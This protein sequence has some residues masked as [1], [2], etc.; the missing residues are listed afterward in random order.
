MNQILRT[1]QN[2]F[3]QILLTI[4]ILFGSLSVFSQYNVTSPLTCMPS[5]AGASTDHIFNSVTPPAA[6]GT[7]TLYYRGDID[8]ASEIISLFDENGVLIGQTIPSGDFADQC[9]A[10][11][12]SIT[13]PV[14]VAQLAAWT[15]DGIVTFTS[16]PDNSVN[17]TL[18]TP[19][20]ATYVNLS[21]QDVTGPDNIGIASIDGPA[22]FCAGNEDV[23]VTVT[24]A[25]TNPVDTFTVSWTVDNGPV[26]SV[27]YDSISL[28]TFN[29]V[30]PNSVQLTLVNLNITAATD[31]KVWTS[32]P[33][34]NPDT[35]N[36]NDTA[37]T[38]FT[39]A[40][41]GTFTIDPAGSGASN[42]VDFASAI[43]SVRTAGLCGPV[44]FNIAAGT[45][46]ENVY[47]DQ[48]TGSSPVNSI[49]FDGGSAATTTITYANSLD[50][51]TVFLDG[52]DFVTFT[53]LT[54]ENT[55]QDGTATDAFGIYLTNQADFNTISNCTFNIL[56]TT[57]FDA[58]AIMA[59]ASR[60]AASAGNNANNLTIFDVNIP[61]SGRGIVLYGGSTPPTHNLT[62]SII[63]CS[64]TD[65][66]STG[67][68][69]YVDGQT[70]LTIAGNTIRTAA[71]VNADGIYCLQIDQYFI[72]ENDVRV[73]DWGLYILDGNDGSNPGFQ[74]LV[75]NN[76]F[77]SDA[78]YGMYLNDFEYTDIFHNSSSGNPAI[79]INDQ[80]NTINFVNN[81]FYSTSD[82]AFESDDA[83]TPT[84][85]IDFNIYF[86][87]GA[88]PFDI[89]PSVF[90]DLASWQISDP[91][92]NASSIEGDPV[93]V[94]PLSDLH[95]NGILPNDVGNNAAGVSIDIDGDP[96]PFAGATT[97]DIGADEF[98]PPSCP[99]PSALAVVAAFD[100]SALVG[101][102]EQGTATNWEVEYGPTGFAQG[103]GT[104]AS[105][106][107]N[108]YNITGLMPQTSYDFYVRS[109]CGAGDTSGWSGPSSFTTTCAVASAPFFDNLDG[110]G[111][112]ADNGGS[113]INS[114]IDQCWTRIPDVT[115]TYSWRVRT[116]STGSGSGSTGPISDKSGS[117]NYI[118]TEASSGT[119]GSVAE[120]YTPF[121]DVTGI[122]NPQVDYW[123]HFYGTQINIMYVDYFDGTSWS[124]VDSIAG[125]QQ[126]AGTDP[127]LNKVI[128]L[129]PGTVIQIRFRAISDGC[130]AGDL[131]IDE[132]F[133]G[134]PPT[135][136]APQSV[137]AVVVGVDSAI[138]TLSDSVNTTWEVEYGIAGFIPGTGTSFVTTDTTDTI[139][140]LL[141]NTT[142]EVFV[143]AICGPGDTS[144]P[145]GP[146]SFTTPCSVFSAPWADNL[147]G[148]TWVSDNSSSSINSQIDQCWERNPNNTT[149]YSWRVRTT[150]TGSG[151][152]STGPAADKS[153]TGNYAYTEASSGASGNVAILETPLVDISSLAIPQLKFWYHF[154]G[155]TINRMYIEVSDGSGWITLD[156][157]VGQQQ[158]SGTA[159]WLEDSVIIPVTGIVQARF[160]AI[161][162]G[163]CAG[164]L[165]IDEVSISDGPSCVP[166]VAISD[167]V[168]TGDSVNIHFTD[169]SGATGWVYEYG[170]TGFT[171][172]TG[173][174]DTAF[175]NPFGIGGLVTNA[176]YDIY[177]RSICGA[178]TSS[179]SGVY[180]FDV[181]T[182]KRPT[183]LSALPLTAN[184]VEFS[185]M[186]NSGA[187]QWEIEY[188]SAGFIPGTGTV[189]VTSNNPDTI[190]GL[191]SG[192]SY[193]FFV[194]ST[195]G[196]SD[197]SLW[198]GPAT[199][200]L[201]Y[202]SGGPSSTADSE[203]TNVLLNGSFGSIS[204]LQ[205]CPAAAG[206][207]DFTAQ[208]A[209]LVTGLTYTL[210]VTFGTCGGTFPGAGEAWID[211]NQ[212]LTFEPG[213]SLGTWSGTGEPQGSTVFNGQFTFTVPSGT[214][215]G[216]TRM[217]VMQW[218]GGTNPLD[219]C[220]TFT[221]GSI[222]DYTILVDSTAPLCTSVSGV[223][224]SNL[225]ADSAIVS[226][227]D[228]SG[229]S[230]SWNIEYGI[231]GFILGSGTIV[232]TTSN[233]DTVGGLL[234]NSDY[235]FY[236]TSI[237]GAGDTAFTVGPI[238][239]TTPCAVFAAPWSDNLDGGSWLADDVGFSA[240]NSVIDQCWTR[241]PDNTTTYSWRVRSTS[242]GSASTGPNTD[243]SGTG[244]YAYAEA[245]SGASGNVA[246]LITPLV[247]I[248]SL[249]IP[250]LKY[251]Y[252]FYGSE[253]NVM[254]VEVNDGSGWI[255][256]DSI[257][258]QQQTS[259]AAPWLQDS[260]LIPVTGTIQAR[261]RAISAGCCGGDL[262]IDEVSI[263]QGPSCVPPIAIFDSV[264]TGDSVN[265][266][267]TD[268][269]GATGWV[270]E[271]GITGFVPGTGTIDTA[272][273][274]PFG[275]GGLTTN[276]T[277]DVYIRS[278]CGGSSSSWSGAYTF[279]VITCKAP[280]N[281]TAIPTNS[282]DVEFGWTENSGATQ[283]E[284]EY[285]PQGFL[286]GT[287]T[288][289]VTA[290]NP[291]TTIGLATGNSY[292]F[293]VRST[294]GPGDTSLWSGPATVSL[295]Y[296][297]GGPTST[298]D[299]EVTNVVLNGSFGSIS[300]LQTCPAA[301]GVQDF[302]AQS[303]GLV[304]DSTYTLNVTFGT[305][306]GTF[307]GAGEAWIDWN[308]NLTFEPGESLGTWSGLAEP[309][310]STVYNGQFTFTVPSGANIGA[311]RMRV[312][313]WEGGINPLDPCGT[314]TWGSIED[315]TIIVDSVAPTC[316]SVS[317]LTVGAVGPDTAVVSWT[318]PGS[319]TSWDIEFGVSGFAQGTGTVVN[320]TYKS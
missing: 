126:T 221:W 320:A 294:C 260:V 102:V 2:Y 268:L 311:T 111:W 244:N 207:Q 16:T 188:G 303:A 307:N 142:Y 166:P 237:C 168:I 228:T 169:L 295:S 267:F 97:V 29:G 84:D 83:L 110:G 77:I 298:G 36:N 39:P 164:D 95:I 257:V 223:T 96:R 308:Q 55:T 279:S 22:N 47:L 186:E 153:G 227:T 318:D 1:N 215:I 123:Y 94:D 206:V 271:Y 226:W 296:C 259:S 73:P 158:T 20:G 288:T 25:G 218:E 239:I 147:D 152:T 45:Y 312:M 132:V 232:N 108:P 144:L 71:N 165:A 197:T 194:R 85:S 254:Y 145:A 180:T 272:T 262:A 301:A 124:T 56:E 275:I 129:S 103:T 176:T 231:S 273:T 246:S 216:A 274:N 196:P 72:T 70:E 261:F 170:I 66:G 58:V 238:T 172:G 224:V 14:S 81:I 127:W 99:Q 217:R 87:G 78:D 140:G 161:S 92:R 229:T 282:T 280:T 109:I 146:A 69:I 319:G 214:N 236:V 255:A 49:T 235:D 4:G 201:N 281:L 225:G 68:G 297:S 133:V 131:A 287:G 143:K 292:D 181:I 264:I 211:W 48:I 74:S 195:C 263:E 13:F 19:C 198:S 182:C 252:H 125:G 60:T 230:T 251:W 209:G 64:I 185:W 23:I 38:T 299:S 128:P 305:C 105:T 177:L 46:N 302:T 187:T 88:N 17:S 67:A 115:T 184:S 208:S 62:N 34:N 9:K 278:L 200:S 50:T 79:R 104:V 57:S 285:G 65:F 250:Q 159:A 114:I 317:G 234:P 86:S 157:I 3:T 75:V 183:M 258:G 247:D 150:S 53:N 141:A 35:V 52:T 43:Q 15:A 243:L 249:T 120:I 12:D 313:Q 6:P 220:G 245:S 316:L 51:P 204:N 314:F 113:S 283:W 291:D 76:M 151:S 304:T 174:V 178:S 192:A 191:A 138:I 10:T 136:P 284:I 203:V 306:G 11:F 28:D 289:V 171:P 139:S 162:N 265:I 309:Q 24:N 42:F 101:W 155:T 266:Y 112:V 248:S 148:G 163:C 160:R 154:Y 241:D 293:Y 240:E 276:S 54:I 90:P 41:A 26:T 310:G 300:N 89:G 7:V 91:S 121:I 117:G 80:A 175:T 134:A 106:T 213:E 253:I 156:S 44:V 40:L 269:S 270:Y 189:I 107:N 122:A 190:L 256:V 202:C 5:P 210:N 219:P 242:T 179:W 137:S 59:S 205:T 32:L 119:S 193:D 27:L 8:L 199:V 37:L 233:P 82:F 149:T 21:Y 173:T 130:C 167:S 118:Y 61:S 30:N 33:N 212:N 286:Q 31:F 277:Y 100:V 222:E 18:C 116:T 63:N 135:C 290:N 315:Y 98:A 93:F